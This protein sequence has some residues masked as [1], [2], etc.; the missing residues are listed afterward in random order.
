MKQLLLGIMAAFVVSI[1]PGYTQGNGNVVLAFDTEPPGLD[2]TV[3]ASTAT[4]AA[5]WMNVYEGLTRYT[6]NGQIEGSLAESWT[7]DKGKVFTFKLRPGVKFHDGSDFNA[8]DVIFTLARAGAADSTNPRKPVFVNIESVE[9]VDPLTVKVTLKTPSNLFLYH[10]AE[11]TAA[12]VGPETA[13]Q[14]VATPIGTGPYRVVAWNR[15]DKIELEKFADYNGA[16]PG[17]IQKATIRYMG[18]ANAMA[19]T[20]RA[21]DIDY[22]PAVTTLES[23]ADFQNDTNFRVRVGETQGVLGLVLNNSNEALSN[24]KVRQALFHAVDWRA[25][26]EVAHSGLGVPRGTQMTPVNPFYVETAVPDRYDP[27]KA[28]ALLDEAGV[29]GLTITFKILPQ[30]TLVRTAE[31]VVAQLA[32]AG[33]EAKIETLQLAQWLDVVF[34]NA[35]YDATILTQQESW[36]FLTYADPER[37]NKYDNKQFQDLITAAEQ[38]P[39]L[40]EAKEKMAEAQQLLASDMPTIWLYGAPNVSI[41]K[42]ELQGVWENLPVPAYPISHLSWQ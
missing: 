22:I 23:V 24:P 8:D 36:A 5:T 35:S 2:P 17:S 10:L 13:T 39:S 11:A 42:A 34:K 30:P 25:V 28:A 9:A 21:G 41:S 12:M 20:L 32:E 40:D 18:N 16:M 29:P 37:F 3:N 27:A 14:N 1:S 33:I 19:A 6:A 7:V 38:A 31:I 4:S 15:G 26:N